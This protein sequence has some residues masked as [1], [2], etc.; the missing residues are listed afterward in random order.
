MKVQQSTRKHKK[1]H[2]STFLYFLILSYD[3]FTG[4]QVP[5]TSYTHVRPP[6]LGGRPYKLAIYPLQVKIFLPKIGYGGP[7][8]LTSTPYKWSYMCVN[9]KGYLPRCGLSAW[10]ARAGAPSNRPLIARA[11][12]ARVDGHTIRIYDHTSSAHAAGASA[13]G[14]NGRARARNGRAQY[15]RASRCVLALCARKAAARD[16][17]ISIRWCA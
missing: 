5:L 2:E 9:K 15:A 7:K 6:L 17:S 4:G 8:G 13:I 12:N 1:V 14:T 11:G 3:F 10:D 16:R